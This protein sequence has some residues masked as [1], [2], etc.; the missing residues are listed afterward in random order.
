MY[1]RHYRE[2][3]CNRQLLHGV[4]DYSYM[5]EK[6]IKVGVVF[7]K[8]KLSET[9]KAN[10]SLARKKEWAECKRI[11]LEG[12]Q[13]HWANKSGKYNRNLADWL[14]LCAKCHYHYDRGQK[15]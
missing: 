4:A 8:R 6:K 12:H 11:E 9:H 14:R 15:D 3:L 2:V 13:I 1:L 7:P 5:D 10:I